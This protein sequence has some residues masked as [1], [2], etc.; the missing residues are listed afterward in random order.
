MERTGYLRSRA[1]C[2]IIRQKHAPTYRQMP[3]YTHTQVH[4]HNPPNLHMHDN[5]IQRP[6]KNYACTFLCKHTCIHMYRHIRQHV[7]VCTCVLA[8]PGLSLLLGLELGGVVFTVTK[9]GH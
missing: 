3:V 6:L 2:K 9:P 8:R 4:V 1:G 7:C 5:H